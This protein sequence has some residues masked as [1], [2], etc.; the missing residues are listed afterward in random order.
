[1]KMAATTLGLVVMA[2]AMSATPF[3]GQIAEPVRPAPTRT[4]VAPGVHLFQTASYG[5]VGLDG[6]AVVITSEDGVLV[7][8]SNGTPAAAR[9]VIAGI[10]A[11]TSQPVKY[12]VNSH[13]HWDHWYGTEAYVEAFPGVQVIAH[14]RSRQLMAGPAIEFNRP[15]LESQL[16]GY[17][18]MLED[19]RKA[20]PPPQNPAALDAR[21]AMAKWFLDAKRAVKHVL[22]TR[23][24][25]DRLTVRLG[26]REVQ[27]VHVD[28]A[29]TPGDTMI[30]LPQ[31]KVLLAAD[32][33]VNPISFALS[34]YPAGWIRTLEWIDTLNPA[35]IVGGH[36]EPMR[37]ESRLHATLSI[38]RTL[39]E[40]GAKARARGLDAFAAADE[41]FPLVR[42]PM[43]VLTGDAAQLNQAFRG[44]LVEWFMH[45]VYD[46]LAG[47]MTDAIAPIPARRPPG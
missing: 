33:L 15:G 45:R 22:P 7:F 17:V 13:W 12:V 35:V 36:G 32:V 40:H 20:S 27:L 25:T 1:M 41:A 26:S 4:E 3:G 28:R 29:V 19:R 39:R 6:N 47:P 43:L 42:E 14:E 31:E 18:T 34:S 21:I 37:D 10:R 30:Y 5:D 2:G 38:F 11:I 23:T 9:D 8:D 46:E 24:Y 16:P 44:Q